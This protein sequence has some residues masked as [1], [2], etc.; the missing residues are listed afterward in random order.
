MSQGYIATNMAGLLCGL[1][2][3]RPSGRPIVLQTRLSHLWNKTGKP[4]VVKEEAGDMPL[5]LLAKTQTTVD[6]REDTTVSNF[7]LLTM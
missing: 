4:P 1:V 5:R 3:F 2:W 6:T 7:E